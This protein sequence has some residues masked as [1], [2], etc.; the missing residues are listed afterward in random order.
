MQYHLSLTKTM[1][2]LQ[3]IG[4]LISLKKDIWILQEMIYYQTELTRIVALLVY[5][6]LSSPGKL[7]VRT[8]DIVRM[9]QG[10]HL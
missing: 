9:F 5:R 4:N 7:M 8:Y 1:F 2:Y 10:K 6:F 3:P